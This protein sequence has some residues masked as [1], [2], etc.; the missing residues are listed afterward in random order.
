M[1]EG[2]EIV[3]LCEPNHLVTRA[4][5]EGGGYRCLLC[6]RT[7]MVPI[8]GGDGQWRRETVL[9][10]SGGIRVQLNPLT[11]PVPI[12]WEGGGTAV[13]HTVDTCG[14]YKW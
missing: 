9:E 2:D 7:R 14:G 8:K 12:L 11:K 10:N 4:V 5:E 6:R 13:N 1:A 3:F